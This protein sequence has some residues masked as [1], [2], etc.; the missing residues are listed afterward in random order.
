MR[1]ILNFR[2][3][4]AL[5]ATLGTITIGLI[6]GCS[7]GGTAGDLPDSIGKVTSP[8][9]SAAQLKN[10]EQTKGAG[11]KGAPGIAGGGSPKR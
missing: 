8:E 10:L 3:F 6:A 2:G 5:A 9:E 1:R 11:Y 7:D 4:L